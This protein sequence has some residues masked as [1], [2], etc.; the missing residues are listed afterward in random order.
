MSVKPT[1][2]CLPTRRKAWPRSEFQSSLPA[3]WHL[4]VASSHILHR[5]CVH[6]RGFCLARERASERLPAASLPAVPRKVCECLLAVAAFAVR[7]FQTPVAHLK[8][9]APRIAPSLPGAQNK[10]WPCRQ[11]PCLPRL[12]GVRPSRTSCT[13]PS[14]LVTSR[15]RFGSGTEHSSFYTELPPS[16]AH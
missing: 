11:L 6:S 16:H 10:P 2:T 3:A 13:S 4:A 5:S 8:A 9:N 14:P 15:R 12:P 1:C 7:H